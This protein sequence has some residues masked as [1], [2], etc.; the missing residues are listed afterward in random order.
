M[1]TY[2]DLPIIARRVY[3]NFIMSNLKSTTYNNYKFYR[4]DGQIKIEKQELKGRSK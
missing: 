2:L 4:E 3:E 1:I